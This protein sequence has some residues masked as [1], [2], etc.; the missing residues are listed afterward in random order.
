[1]YYGF[2]WILGEKINIILNMVKCFLLKYFSLFE[3]Y[4][5]LN[6]YHSISFYKK[7]SQKLMVCLFSVFKNCFCILKNKKN[8]ENIKNAKF[9][10][11]KN[12]F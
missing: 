5:V 10:Y 2:V 11:N 7:K 9:R 8:K 3:R 4:I 12:N 6:N 1:M